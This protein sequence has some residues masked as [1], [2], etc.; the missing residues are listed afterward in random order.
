MKA[1]STGG[2][3]VMVGNTTRS[4]TQGTCLLAVEERLP[5]VAWRVTAMMGKLVLMV[6]TGKRPRKK[7]TAARLTT[8]A[9]RAEVEGVLCPAGCRQEAEDGGEGE[10]SVERQMST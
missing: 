7:R 2:Q 9:A 10:E 8:A 1:T 4:T 3:Q 6:K 5:V